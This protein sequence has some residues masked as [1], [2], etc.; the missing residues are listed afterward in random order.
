MPSPRRTLRAAAA[1]LGAIVM[2]V[3]LT[4]PASA[5]DVLDDHTRLFVDHQST[6]YQAARHL[7][8]QA[9]LDALRLG[10]YPG[11]T[12]FTGGTPEEV[13]ADV[14]ALV[15]RTGRA[16]PV[17]VA[18][19]LPYRDCGQY[20][21][22]GALSTADYAAWIE[23]FA[24]G[25]G[26]RPAV[27]ILEPDGLGLIPNHTSE[28]DGSQNCT[29]DGPEA[30]PEARFAQLNHAV[31]VL[32][33]LPH[34]A[35]YLDATHSSWQN[36]SES[37][38]RLLKAGVQRAD[39]FFLNASN[40]EYTTNQVFYG[41]WISQCIETAVTSPGWSGDPVAADF[42]DCAN[43]YWNGGPEGTAIADLLGP[44]TGVALNAYGEWSEDATD[45]ALNVSG[46]SARYS[47][48]AKTHFVIDTS[49]NGQGPWDWAAAGYPDAG[50][51]QSW[52]NPP[53]RGLGLRP[54]TDTGDPLVDAYLWIKVPGESD[55]QCTRD[56]SAGDLDPERGV[57]D[58]AAGQW[59]A[60]QARELISLADP[61]LWPWHRAHR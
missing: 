52:C 49:R 42:P 24:A 28:L 53:D 5:D 18:Y 25:I 16:V 35:V 10:R 4:G 44:W 9:K 57:V 59:F 34:T 22:G 39:G 21:A 36:V 61:A 7:H 46:I 31:D 19:D 20:S 11:A 17:L 15:R 29:V 55:G 45:P 6:T 27:V 38:F 3:S 32:G 8:G 41:T 14:R 54:T 26:N 56:G 48:Q 43:Q 1:I 33:A 37:A 13:R 47:V 60:Q 30:T 58:P 2:G 51:A 12:W 40:Y 50:T 23:A